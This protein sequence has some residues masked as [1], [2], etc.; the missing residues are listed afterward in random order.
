RVKRNCLRAPSVIRSHPPWF[1]GRRAG[2]CR[3]HAFSPGVREEATP[4]CVVQLLRG[5]GRAAPLGLDKDHPGRDESYRHERRPPPVSRPRPEARPT[6]PRNLGRH[7]RSL[8]DPPPSSGRCVRTPAGPIPRRPL[9]PTTAFTPNPR[10]ARAP[11]RVGVRFRCPPPLPRSRRS[12][13]CWPIVVGAAVG[14][15]LLVAAL[16]ALIPHRRPAA[17]AVPT[18]EVNPA[19]LA[20]A[21]AP[22]EAPPAPQQQVAAESV[23]VEAPPAPEQQATVLPTTEQ[24][25][26][27]P[28]VAEQQASAP[29]SSPPEIA[30]SS[31]LKLAAAAQ[32]KGTT[33]QQYGTAVNFYDSPEEARKKAQE[34]GK[35]L[36]VLH[37]AGNFEEPGFT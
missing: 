24:H 32:G 25:V 3:G 21:S 6:P 36:F 33:C 8:L 1:A 18:V 10:R 35:L 37:V 26:T 16:V 11:I 31:V 17:F 28:P 30:D 4:G 13:I 23:R 14:S 7:L 29:P 12:I 9:M 15:L 2:G 19:L 5:K 20:A 22:V 34:E 27:A